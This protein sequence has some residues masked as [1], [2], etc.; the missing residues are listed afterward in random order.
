[1]HLGH[2]SILPGLRSL[3]SD[4]FLSSFGID[5]ED[6][7]KDYSDSIGIMYLF[8]NDHEIYSSVPSESITVMHLG[9]LSILPGLRNQR[10]DFFLSS[11]G[12]DYSDIKKDYSDASWSFDYSSMTTKSTLRFLARPDSVALS[13]IGFLSP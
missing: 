5:Y 4:F 8:F 6:T 10:A 2:L 1:M 7:Q 12:I 13:A 11:F 9:H 3:P